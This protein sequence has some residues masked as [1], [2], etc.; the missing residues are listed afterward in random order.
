MK[1]NHRNTLVDDGITLFRI[2]E[3]ETLLT[4][5]DVFRLWQED[6]EFARY[7]A[8]TITSACYSGYC[9]ETPPIT[10]D[11]IDCEHEFVVIDSI[12]HT[13][14]NQ[15]WAPF[16][17]HFR[18]GE[19]V[20]AFLNLGKTGTM[21]A[22]TPDSS[23]DGASIASFLRTASTDRV[24]ALWALV[25]REM[26]SKVNQVPIWL[27][28]AGLG[29]SWLHVRLDPRPKYYRYLPYKRKGR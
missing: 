9:W 10:S 7:Y 24:V 26:T 16:A 21:I 12:T 1:Y 11:V 25:G 22:P 14:L 23:F 18:K 29:V 17:E 8:Y 6:A 4:H 27:S 5:R 13:G 28:T 3:D 19:L 20:T 2:Y 15:N